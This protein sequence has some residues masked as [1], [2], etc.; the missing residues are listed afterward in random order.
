MNQ[1]SNAIDKHQKLW[2][3]CFKAIISWAIYLWL[4]SFLPLSFLYIYSFASCQVFAKNYTI[5]I[6][7][8]GTKTSA[9]KKGKKKNFAYDIK[10]LSCGISKKRKENGLD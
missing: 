4:I 1:E 8:Y 10:K 3:L 7:I 9:R 2:W 6:Q 5:P